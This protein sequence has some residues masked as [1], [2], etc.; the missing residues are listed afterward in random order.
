MECSKLQNKSEI[1]GTSAELLHD[2]CLYPAVAHTA[3]YSCYQLMKHIWLYS[4]EK[5][6]DELKR[7]IKQSSM[8]SHE[9]LINEIVKYVVTNNKTNDNLKDFRNKIFKLKVLRTE[10][11]YSDKNFDYTNS[12]DSISLSKEILSVLKK[13]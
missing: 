9:Y 2:K 4:M 12:R 11:D 1:L 5:S 6:E 3:Y 7:N 10:A 8:G 13:Y